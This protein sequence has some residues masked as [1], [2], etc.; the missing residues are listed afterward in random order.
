MND[1]A[2]TP[3]AVTGSRN[4]ALWLVIGVPTVAVIASLVTVTLAYRGADA[5]L[6][7]RYHW[8]GAQ[9]GADQ[10]RLDAAA[11]QDIAMDFRFDA[12]AGQCR[13][14]LR[15]AAPPT[16]Q[17]DLAHATLAGFDQH[18]TLQRV[19]AVYVGACAPLTAG[20]WWLQLADPGGAWL[21][22]Q[23]IAW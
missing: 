12:T 13:I 1:T 10:A 19:G 17:L 9:L 5:P 20:R 2:A 14:V 6:P 18:V 23:R 16:L 3:P 4:P 8:E 7:A 11:R 22:R 21:L 15:G